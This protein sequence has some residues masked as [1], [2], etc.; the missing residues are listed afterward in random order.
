MPKT[1]MSHFEGP[2]EAVVY[3]ANGTCDVND[4][5]KRLLGL[6]TNSIYKNCC[7]PPRIDGSPR[8]AVVLV[9]LV[10]EPVSDLS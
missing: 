7:A 2:R 5:L 6:K 10:P 8:V 1:S 3:V 9:L 4:E